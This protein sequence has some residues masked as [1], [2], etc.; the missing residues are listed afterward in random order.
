MSHLTT[1]KSKVGDP[2][3]QN[4]KAVEMAAERLGMAVSPR[5][6]FRAW[7]RMYP[8]EMVLEVT[9]EKCR[10]LRLDKFSIYELGI[11]KDPVNDGSYLTSHDPFD[12]QLEK[13]IG[14]TEYDRNGEPTSLAP[15]FLQHYRMSVEQL[16]AEA[17][18]ERIEW[19]ANEDKSYTCKVY[20][21][22]ERVRA[23]GL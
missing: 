6:E 13:V 9:A 3:I 8:A 14:K 23:G 16:T 10:E 11:V 22:L 1:A 2:L 20:P 18:G 17:L 7:G 12:S 5:K 15:I 4:L 19:I 21:N